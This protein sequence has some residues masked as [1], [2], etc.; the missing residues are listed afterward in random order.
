MFLYFAWFF[1]EAEIARLKAD[2]A[3][4]QNGEMAD[5]SGEDDQV[6][7]EMQKLRTTN[8]KLK[9]RITHLKRVSVLKMWLPIHAAC[10]T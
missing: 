10:C 2:I 1:Q 5:G 3:K 9:F 6:S 4:L 7:P 8:E